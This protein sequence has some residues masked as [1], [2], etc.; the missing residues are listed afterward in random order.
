MRAIACLLADLLRGA[1]R[2]MFPLASLAVL[3]ALVYSDQGRDVLVGLVEFAAEARHGNSISGLLF[4]AAGCTA[5]SLSVWY[6]MRWLLTAEMPALPLPDP[7]D[8]AQR[9]LPRLMGGL[10]PALVA[11][12]LFARNAGHPTHALGW[13]LGFSALAVAV[14]MLYAWRGDLL[15]ALSRRGWIGSIAGR[16]GVQPGRLSAT[17]PLPAL[18]LRIVVWSIA[19]TLVIGLMMVLFPLTLPRVIGAAAVA[20]LALAS[21]N[22]FGSFVLT[23]WPLRHGLPPLAV[24]ALLVAAVL[25][26]VNDNHRVA[27]LAQAGAPPP[28]LPLV[29]DFKRFLA[30]VQRPASGPPTV[31]FVASEG[32]GVRAAYWT[33]AVLQRLAERAPELFKHN[34]YALSGVSGG[35]L[36]VAA[37]LMSRRADYCPQVAGQAAAATSQAARTATDS[38][39]M[40]FVA[41]AV[42]GL[43]YYDF[44]QRFLPFPVPAFDRSR[45]MEQGWQNAF[46]NLAGLPFGQTMDALY[47]DCPALP[48][49]LLNATVVETGQ[50]AVLGPLAM[51]DDARDACSVDALYLNAMPAMTSDLDTRH[52]PLAGLVH[53]SAR[54]PLISPAGTV[55]RAPRASCPTAFRL[56]DGGY[57]D[58]SGAQTVLDL[59]LQLRE[60]LPPESRDFRALVLVVRNEAS[61]LCAQEVDEQI[62]PS[63]IAPEITAVVGALANARGSH[64]VAARAALRRADIDVVDLAVQENTDAANAPLGWALSD[65]ARATLD[66]AAIARAE[67]AIP[68]LAQGSD[69]CKTSGK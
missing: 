16:H 49:L 18:T 39:G 24:V 12:N 7:P 6:S 5:L 26:A 17:D 3:A 37:W 58:N 67:H 62:A 68:L 43:F 36:G 20:A 14:V 11:L 15:L 54:F 50:R 34:L 52:Q 28:R 41:P 9:W 47:H 27:T 63:R 56:V 31:L 33:A 42:A 40:D 61:P 22:L 65:R 59:V 51:D 21:I 19:L 1:V 69:P 57:F 53:H 48:R 45:A 32:G 13:A 46:A 35:S 55:T 23:Y 8:W 66:R 4:L 60:S 44:A 10:A 64:A 25:G 30:T 29:A 38:L 2:C